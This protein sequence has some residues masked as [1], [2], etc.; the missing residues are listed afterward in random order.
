MIKSL[1]QILYL[2]FISLCLG[3]SKSDDA[4]EGGPIVEGR[5]LIH[6][7][8][9]QNVYETIIGGTHREA[10]IEPGNNIFSLILNDA[11]ENIDVELILTDINSEVDAFALNTTFPIYGF[12]RGGDGIFGTCQF[13]V[14]DTNHNLSN[15]QLVLTNVSP[16]NSDEFEY[17]NAYYL[18]ATFTMQDPMGYEIS[19]ELNNVIYRSFGCN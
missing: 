13:K 16:V 9:N 2:L 19:G 5:I 12:S 11:I 15:G 7:N 4:I 3:C 6:Y 1:N 10:C 8:N 17:E 14:S 18:S